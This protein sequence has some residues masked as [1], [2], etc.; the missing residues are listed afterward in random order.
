MGWGGLPGSDSS[1][2]LAYLAVRKMSLR[3]GGPPD[4]QRRRRGSDSHFQALHLSG[5]SK[6]TVLPTQAS[7]HPLPRGGGPP[8]PQ[9]DAFPTGQLS[10]PRAGGSACHHVT[11]ARPY[12]STS[13]ATA[14]RWAAATRVHVRPKW[15]PR[16]WHPALLPDLLSHWPA[17]LHTPT[18]RLSAQLP[19][20]PPNFPRGGPPRALAEKLKAHGI[21]PA[22]SRLW[23][24]QK[25]SGRHCAP[26]HSF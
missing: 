4:G 12:L 22:P 24:L 8:G 19:P 5:C 11:W 23:G 17:G 15:G 26:H 9:T 3:M 14:R 13:A 10:S 1:S 18:P 21:L 20:A 25:A 2:T 6:P 7:C 16:A